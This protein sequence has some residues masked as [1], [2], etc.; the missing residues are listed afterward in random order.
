MVI[1]FLSHNCLTSY[2]IVVESFILQFGKPMFLKYFYKPATLCCIAT[3]L[4]FSLALAVDM[5]EPVLNP[6]G[7]F[8][9]ALPT[10]NGPASDPTTFTCNVLW[11][12]Y[13]SVSDTVP[14]R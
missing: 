14:F 2:V 6:D 13:N 10:I 7:S 9:A 5:I 8:T 12:Q 1:L 4:A 3:L 11:I